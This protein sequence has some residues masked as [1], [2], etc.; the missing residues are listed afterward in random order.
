MG[1]SYSRVKRINHGR[2]RS[3]GDLANQHR[4]VGS[5]GSNDSSRTDGNTFNNH[6]KHLSV[7]RLEEKT[8]SCTLR[9]NSR[10]SQQSSEQE[11]TS[12]ASMR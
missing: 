12:K 8:V 5:Q 3:T 11:P 7:E 2:S 6:S 9:R 1:S 4:Y 10:H